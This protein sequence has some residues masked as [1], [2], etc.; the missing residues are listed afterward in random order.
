VLFDHCFLKIDLFHVFQ[1]KLDTQD[2]GYLKI[3]YCFWALACWYRWK[4]PNDDGREK[5]W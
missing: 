1:L 5:W 4:L 3:T 2:L